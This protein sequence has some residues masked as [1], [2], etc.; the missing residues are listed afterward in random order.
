MPIYIDNKPAINLA[1]NYAASKFT[2][3][4]GIDHHFI[5]EHCESGSKTFKLIWR[6]SEHQQADGMTKPLPKSKFAKFRDSVVSNI[7][8]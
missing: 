6:N 2:R 7:E 3:H 1:N 5:R 8:L 4:I